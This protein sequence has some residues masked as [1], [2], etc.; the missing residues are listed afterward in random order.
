MATRKVT[1][2]EILGL[3]RYEEVR[4]ESRR[5]IIEMKRA[6]RV[7]VGDRI[8]FVFENHETM[9][10]QVQEMLR[11]ERIVDLDRI[12]DEIDV[13]NSLIPEPGEL[14]STMLI[15]ITDSSRIRDE[16]VGLV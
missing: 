8:T 13:Y 1:L 15:E 6:R 9:L 16:L 12:R 10:F 5:R 2:D 7:P 3:A 14:S 4:D 11:A